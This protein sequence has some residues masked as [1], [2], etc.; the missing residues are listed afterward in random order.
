MK[1]I[2]RKRELLIERLESETFVYDTKQHRAHSLNRTV[3]CVW[4]NSNG[5]NTVSD[6]AALLEQTAGV[7]YDESLVLVALK[8]LEK[9]HLLDGPP[10]LDMPETLPSRR[11]LAHRLTAAGGAA[12]LLPAIVSIIAPVPA[13][14]GSGRDGDGDD[15]HKHK[16]KGGGGD[17]GWW[18]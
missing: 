6:L 14:A 13:M 4:E 16:G 11:D 2:A 1:P 3:S 17:D 7:P 8:Q 10:N 5:E 15:K 18:W 12:F 9:I